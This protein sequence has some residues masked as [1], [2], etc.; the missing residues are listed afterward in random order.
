MATKRKTVPG[1]T[2]TPESATLLDYIQWVDDPDPHWRNGITYE[3]ICAG[4]SSTFDLCVSSPIVTGA[5]PTKSDNGG[6]GW[7]GATPFT[8]YTE[9]DCSPVGF[10]DDSERIL[11]E[12]LRRYEHLQV[13]EVFSTGVVAGV[14][15]I[16]M[17]HLSANAVILDP[18]DSLITLQTA[19]S[20]PVTGSVDVVEGLGIIE[21]SIADCLGGQGT[22]HVTLA[23]FED[24]VNAL[25]IFQRNGL[26]YT[27][28]G[29]FVVPG[30]GYTGNSPAGAAPAAGTSWMYATGPVFGYRGA[31]KQVGT[32]TD[33]LNRSVNTLLLIIERTYVLGTVCCHTGVLV[34]TG[35]AVTG[36]ANSAA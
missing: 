5:N 14:A 19:A 6:R 9:V 36:T 12:A 3:E 26:W 35:G 30:S 28:K 25:L 24:L 20:V 33:S 8:V 15:N 22:I 31:P 10:W 7:R 16:M 23:V 27:A 2:V 11:A 21:Q 34:S 13:E 1:P 32:R 18:S 29:N 17:P 4:A